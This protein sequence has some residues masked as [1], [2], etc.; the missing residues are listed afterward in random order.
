MIRSDDSE[1]MSPPI[2]LEKLEAMKGLGKGRGSG[3]RE[4][5]NG[6]AY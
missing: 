6:R 4:L 3:R 1:I 2:C 5:Q